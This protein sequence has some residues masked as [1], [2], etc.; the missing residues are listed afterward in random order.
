MVFYCSTLAIRP[1]TVTEEHFV[2]R[3]LQFE[4]ILQQQLSF[5]QDPWF[6]TLYF[7][8]NMPAV[9]ILQ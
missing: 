4:T 9:L 7:S 6:R 3:M 5:Y 2:N 1:K 8:D